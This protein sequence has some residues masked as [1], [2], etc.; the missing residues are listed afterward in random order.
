MYNF[1]VLE[2]YIVQIQIVPCRNWCYAKCT[3]VE[4]EIILCKKRLNE[5]FT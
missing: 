2:F 3:I 4:N 5:V 1:P